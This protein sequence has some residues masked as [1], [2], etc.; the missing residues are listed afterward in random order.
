MDTKWG[1]KALQKLLAQVTSGTAEHEPPD[2]HVRQALD[3]RLT[4][5]RQGWAQYLD[6][7][8]EAL[9]S[10]DLSAQAKPPVKKFLNR[11]LGLPVAMQNRLFS[12]FTALLDA[13]VKL[14]KDNHI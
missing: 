1:Q 2:E 7:A 12:H 11:I 9:V 10:V 14:A 3:L 6:D 8:D 13:E 4:S 5:L